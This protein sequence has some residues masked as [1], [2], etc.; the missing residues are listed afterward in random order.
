VCPRCDT[1]E[2]LSWKQL[3]TELKL[4]G[5]ALDAI[6]DQPTMHKHVPK[7]TREV[8][9]VC[10][11]TLVQCLSVETHKKKAMPPVQIP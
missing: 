3:E 8:E 4:R 10:D 9:D 5:E 1:M 6:W 2:L 11:A 7:K